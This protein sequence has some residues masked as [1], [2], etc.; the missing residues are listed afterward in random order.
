MD[1]VDDKLINIKSTALY[2][3]EKTKLACYVL[4]ILMFGLFYKSLE[5]AESSKKEEKGVNNLI[6]LMLFSSIAY[7]AYIVKS[8]NLNEPLSCL[9]SFQKSR[10]VGLL[11]LLT[12]IVYKINSNKRL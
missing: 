4:C 8:T 9:K 6:Y 1:K 11:L 12:C 5:N 2:F 3:D 10:T 7:Q